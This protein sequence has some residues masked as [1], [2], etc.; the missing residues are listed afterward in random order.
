MEGTYLCGW[1]EN[2]GGGGAVEIKM[3]GKEEQRL[4]GD[5]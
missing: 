2:T 5:L 4:Q 3:E 1:P